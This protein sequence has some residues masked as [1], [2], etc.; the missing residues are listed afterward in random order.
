M[1]NCYKSVICFAGKLLCSTYNADPSGASIFVDLY[2]P[3]AINRMQ[4]VE[5]LVNMNKLSTM[6][7]SD[8]KKNLI[9]AGIAQRLTDVSPE[10]VNEVMKFKT[11]DLIKIV[12][13]QNLIKKLKIII[14]DPFM[15]QME[16]QNPISSAIK[17]IT[18]K[19]LLSNDNE[20]EIFLAIWPYMFPLNGIVLP[21]MKT[22]MKSNIAGRFPIIKQLQDLKFKD[23]IDKMECVNERLE[24]AFEKSTKIREIVQFVKTIPDAEMTQ[25]SAFHIINLLTHSMPKKSDHNLSN[26]VFDIVTKLSVQFEPMHIDIDQYARDSYSKNQPKSLP[27]QLI[28][29]CMQSIIEKTNFSAIFENVIDFTISSDVLILMLKLHG[30]LCNGIFSRSKRASVSYKKAMSQFIRRTIPNID[31][32][33][34][35]FSNFFINHCIDQQETSLRIDP[36]LQFYSMRLFNE[37]LTPM[38]SLNEIPMEVFIRIISGLTSPFQA[39]RVLTC[40]TIGELYRLLD[41][42]SKCSRLL[43]ALLNEKEKI[44]LNEGELYLFLFNTKHQRT[45]LFE[46]IQRSECSMILKATLLNMLKLVHDEKHDTKYLDIAVDVALNILNKVDCSKPTI[47]KLHESI[48]IY[49]TIVRF[50]SIDTISSTSTPGNCKTFFEKVLQQSNVYVQTDNKAE[51]ISVVAMNLNVFTYFKKFHINQQKF[52]IDSI[53]KSATFSKCNNVRSQASKFFRKSIE[54]DAITELDILT[55]MVQV[56]SINTVQKEQPEYLPPELLHTSQWKCGVTLLEFLQKK[57]KK[58][59]KNPLV[60]MRQLFSV[61][62]QCLS[63]DDQSQVEYTKQLALTD[64]LNCC[65]SMSSTGP[66]KESDFKIDL[67]IQCVRGTQNPQTHHHALQLLTKLATMIPESVLHHILEIFMFVGSTVVR[68]DDAYTYQLIS[69]IIKSVVPILKQNNINQVLKVFS[70]ILVDVPNHRL[71]TLYEDVLTTLGPKKILWKFFA[72][73]F[74]TD[75]RQLD[76]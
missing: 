30:K 10:V 13:E 5:N 70:D 49:E 42:S 46:F 71:S 56:T 28:I 19:H 59:L 68:T 8:D 75:V 11:E 23:N 51:S 36:K 16:W 31:Q 76:E 63:F 15:M 72:I 21:H 67:V 22:I 69:N 14:G 38:D 47:L 74:E 62:H 40:N 58:R 33:L 17:H 53:V 20:I 26:G 7:F 60:L 50:E 39:V 35:F 25:L 44:S 73:L 29:N 41:K 45:Q 55:E 61:L 37:L 52:I 27:F 64:I 48:V 2:H 12:G 9:V 4:A 43:G 66:F 34:A 3:S 54:L 6:P 32:Q 1:S 57:Q 65:D 18:S 24:K